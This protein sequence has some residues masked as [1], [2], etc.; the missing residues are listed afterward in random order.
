MKASRPAAPRGGPPPLRPFG[1][2]LRRDGSWRHEGQPIR[3]RRLREHF[4]CSVAYLP[5][6]RKYIVRLG[7]FRGEIEIEETGF[8][9][10]VFDA[11]SGEIA[12]SDR[13]SEPLD[14]ASLRSS[15]HDGALVC[16]VKRE[17]TAEG[18]SARFTH[19]A[20]AELLNAVSDDGK[21]LRLGSRSVSLP[22]L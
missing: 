2:I 14:V 18:L 1:L 16:T 17:L 7:H 8:F 11:A 22:A 4:D 12:L 9:V 10:R 5:E 20:Q 13:S 6:E 15:P 19:A 3:N 21:S